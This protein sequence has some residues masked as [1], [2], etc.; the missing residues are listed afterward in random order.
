MAVTSKRSA[1]PTPT[2]SSSASRSRAASIFSSASRR[3]VMSMIT[4][5]TPSTSP[6]SLMS[7]LYETEREPGPSGAGITTSTMGRPVSSTVDMTVET[8]SAI[9]DGSTS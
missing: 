6:S 7:R 1:S 9:H 4:Q 2:S 8:S 5:L 3:S